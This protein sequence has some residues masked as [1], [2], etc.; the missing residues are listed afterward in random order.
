MAAIDARE[1]FRAMLAAARES[2]GEDV[3]QARKFLSSAARSLAAN[4]KEVTDWLANGEFTRDEAKALMRMHARSAKMT[5]TAAETIG[6]AIAERAVNAALRAVR[7][8]V[9]AVVGFALL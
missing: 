1:L 8:A 4:T 9:N 7:G 3:P 5:L 6:L 2:I